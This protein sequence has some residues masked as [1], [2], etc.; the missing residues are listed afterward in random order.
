MRIAKIKL[1]GII[2]S[3]LAVVLFKNWTFI[4]ILFIASLLLL[5]KGIRKDKLSERIR[6]LILIVF[7]V[8]FFQVVFNHSL[9]MSARISLG[10]ISGLKIFTISL[11]VFLFT[12]TTS[13]SDI[14]SIFSFLP[15]KAQLLITMT[16]SLIP[17]VFEEAHKIRLVQSSRGNLGR[18]FNLFNGFFPVIIPLLH[19]TLIRSEQLAQV[20]ESRGF[21]EKT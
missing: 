19:R 4:V 14:A 5:V 13:P 16:L 11:L 21:Y 15:T 17:L 3:S 18:K 6:P 10:L 8:I 12:S 9:E 2:L 20:M 1:L 7:L